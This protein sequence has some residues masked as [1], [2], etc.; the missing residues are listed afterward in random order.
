MGLPLMDIIYKLTYIYCSRSISSKFLNP[1]VCAYMFPYVCL[2]ISLF[3]YHWSNNQ[4]SINY[5]FWFGTI[6]PF[7]WFSCP[8]RHIFHFIWPKH[9]LVI[10]LANQLMPPSYCMPKIITC[11]HTR[12]SSFLIYSE[13]F[14]QWV[15][16]LKI[17]WVIT[18]LNTRLPFTKCTTSA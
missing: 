16:Q 13:I 14:K 5:V 12:F 10:Q 9:A 11:I 7:I 6:Q 1:S 4:I 2:C 3:I 18:L 15:I 17:N 8:L